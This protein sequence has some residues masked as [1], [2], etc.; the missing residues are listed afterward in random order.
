MV[1]V[2]G[3][4]GW[5]FVSVGRDQPDARAAHAAGIGLRVEAAIGGIV[6]LRLAGC[7]HFEPRHRSLR[8]V[9]GNA[10]RDGEARAAVGAVEERIAIAAV[11]GIEQLAQAIGAGGRVGGNAG[12]DLAARI[13]G[14]DAEV[15]FLVLEE[16][17]RMS[18]GVDARERRCLR[19]QTAA[20]CVDS[21]G[22]PLDLN[23]HA[24]G[25]VA[26]EAGEALLRCEAVDEWAKADALHDAAHRKHFAL[27]PFGRFVPSI[28][29]HFVRL[30]FWHFVRFSFW[31]GFVHRRWKP[32]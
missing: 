8:A 31:S 11:A 18:H 15:L 12:A 14:D 20:K 30:S 29:G 10:A 9:V 5:N 6:V 7:A 21:L 25:V 17:S 3:S 23:G 32:A 27:L 26:D 1:S 13:A 16:C 24:A 4:V 28:F 22:R 2:T 19:L